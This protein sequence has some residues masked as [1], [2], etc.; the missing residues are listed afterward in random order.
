MVY[1]CLGISQVDVVDENMRTIRVEGTCSIEIEPRFPRY[2]VILSSLT[3]GKNK[4]NFEYKRNRLVNDFED[5]ELSFIQENWWKRRLKSRG[6]MFDVKLREKR[7]RYK[8]KIQLLEEVNVLIK[9]KRQLEV[10]EAYFEMIAYG[11]GEEAKGFWSI[12]Y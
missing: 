5:H 8:H 9:F 11:E 2:N 7:C 4:S 6:W 1:C 10:N 12:V 3:K